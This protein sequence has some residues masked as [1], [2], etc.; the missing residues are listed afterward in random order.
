[1]DEQYRISTTR[2]IEAVIGEPMEFV[3][4]KIATQLDD[5]MKE[6]VHR[7]PLIFVST[8]D[9]NGHVDT[10][11]KGDPSGFVMTDELGNLLIPEGPG[12]KLTF[13]F[14]NILRNSEIYAGT[15]GKE[16]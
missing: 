8:I 10:S 5:I 9:E 1:M 14:R 13:G 7:S 6:F 2:E 12:N 15:I 4:A 3:R 16:L 11:P